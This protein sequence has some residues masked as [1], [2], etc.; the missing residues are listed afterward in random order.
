MS[1]EEFRETSYSFRPEELDIDVCFF[2]LLFF[3]QH[4]L[5]LST[6]EMK[7]RCWYIEDNDLTWSSCVSKCMLE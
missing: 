1:P 4:T 2:I 3:K 6:Q 7:R 5:F